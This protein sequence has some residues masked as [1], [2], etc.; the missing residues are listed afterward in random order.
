MIFK[1]L[2]WRV[3]IPVIGALF[4]AVYTVQKHQLEEGRLFAELFRDFNRRY[5]EIH[6]RL[7]LIYQDGDTGDL[8]E[9]D[10]ETLIKYF[11]LCAEEFLYYKSG[12]I[13]PEVWMAW[14]NGMKFYCQR[15]RI[16]HIW[17]KELETDS[18]YGFKLPC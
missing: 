17:A 5:D 18:C 14:H 15:S 11:N 16:R 2:D 7:M 8:C 13:F 9:V 10:S 6:K 1:R 3:F 4:A 12:Y